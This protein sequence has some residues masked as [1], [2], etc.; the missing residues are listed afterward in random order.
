M[1]D[2]NADD[3]FTTPTWHEP[4]R[5]ILAPLLIAIVLCAGIVGLFMLI[6]WATYYTS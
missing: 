6:T 3:G 4:H 5:S 1:T 2:Y